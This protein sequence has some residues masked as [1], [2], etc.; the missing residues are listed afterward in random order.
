[1]RRSTCTLKRVAITRYALLLPLNTRVQS[2]RLYSRGGAT[3]G[4]NIV[5]TTIFSLFGISSNLDVVL[6]SYSNPFHSLVLAWSSSTHEPAAQTPWPRSSLTFPYNWLEK[7]LL[8]L[9]KDL[10]KYL[11]ISALPDI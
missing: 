2:L 1:M 4:I 11:L 10:S 3:S 5:A 9:S 7:D 8:P 6:F